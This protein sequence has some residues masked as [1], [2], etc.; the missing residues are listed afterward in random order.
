MFKF[1]SCVFLRDF[2]DA[3]GWPLRFK[4]PLSTIDPNNSARK[5]YWQSSQ[6]SFDAPESAEQPSVNG[7]WRI[8]VRNEK[9]SDYYDF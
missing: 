8:R 5:A 7:I 1:V 9:K 6:G 4:V 3:S 2:E